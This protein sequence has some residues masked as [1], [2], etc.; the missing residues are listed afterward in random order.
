MVHGDFKL[1]GY[2]L[3]YNQLSCRFSFIEVYFSQD[4]LATIGNVLPYRY[5][6]IYSHYSWGNLINCNINFQC[7]GVDHS[8]TIYPY[9]SIESVALQGCL[10]IPV[11]CPPPASDTL[12][13]PGD[14]RSSLVPLYTPP[15][16][17]LPDS[18]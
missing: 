1:L 9:T 7:K 5:V 3:I 15:G 10:T 17:Y 6:N 18:R 4:V 14:D 11:P 2:R 13:A 8:E 16:P 12:T